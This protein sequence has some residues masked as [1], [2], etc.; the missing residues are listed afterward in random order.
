MTHSKLTL[1]RRSLVPLRAAHVT[2]MPHEAGQ[3]ATMAGS[4]PD[5][6]EGNAG[7]PTSITSTQARSRAE[8]TKAWLD[9][10]SFS[11]SQG[12]VALVS[13]EAMLLHAGPPNHPER[14]ARLAEILRQLDM[15]GLHSICKKVTSREA[16]KEEL[17]RVHTEN[18]VELVSKSATAKKKGKG[19]GLPLGLPILS[20]LFDSQAS[21]PT[22]FF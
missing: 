15:S 12:R 19:W 14:P 11:E 3:L 13:D 20:F 6:A 8:A 21:L 9:A 2:A 22:F 7:H 16:T 5:M 1:A 4:E 17:M 18:H 10:N